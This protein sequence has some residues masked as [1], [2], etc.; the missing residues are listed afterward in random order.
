MLEINLLFITAL[1]CIYVGGGAEIE[2]ALSLFQVAIEITQ[3][4]SQYTEHLHR[5]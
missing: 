4:Y 3:A 1:H 2:R 5:E